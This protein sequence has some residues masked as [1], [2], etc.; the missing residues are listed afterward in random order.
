MEIKLD[1]GTTDGASRMTG[2]HYGVDANL[3]M[4]LNLMVFLGLHC[5]DQILWS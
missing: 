5:I 1:W 2:I 4:K 3:Q